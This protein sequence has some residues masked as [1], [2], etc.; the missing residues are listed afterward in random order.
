MSAHAQQQH[1]Q[2]HPSGI[3]RFLGS[4]WETYAKLASFLK[5]YRFRLALG[6][7][8]GIGYAA[9]N[10]GII[11]LVRTITDT[12]FHGKFSQ[13]DL[14][15]GAGMGQ[16]GGVTEF[17]WMIL[18]IPLVMIL[19]G[20]LAYANVYNL[21]WVSLRALRDMRRR[22]FGHL[23]RQSLDFFGRSQSGRLLS[24]VL[25]DT[26]MAQESL[27][28]IVGEL[29]KQPLTA[30]GVIA[31]LLRIDWKFCLFA[32][33]L[34]PLFL[35]PVIIYGRRVR[36]AARA[37]QNEA[38][39]MAVI[40]Q[41]SFAGIRVIKS[42]AREAF[43]LRLFDK[44]S[45]EQFRS[46][47]K[48]KKSTAIVQPM[49]ESV[50]ACGVALALVYVHY[51][52]LSI[53]SFIALLMGMFLLYDP[54]KNLSRIHVV[55]QNCLGAATS[56]LELLDTKPSIHDLPGAM[57]LETT[58]GHLA[59]EGVNFSYGTT[60]TH[61]EEGGNAVTGIS[62]VIE[63][64]M[65]VALVGSSGAGK[66]TLLALLLRFYDPQQGRILIDG[67][68][69]RDLTLLS[70]RE[71]IGIVTQESFLF[72]DSIYENIR[73]GRLDAT[74]AEIEEAARLA[75]AHDFIMAQPHGYETIVGDKGCLLSGGQQQR[76]AIARALLKA[77]PVLLLDEATSALDSE[78]EKMIQDA[79]EKLSRGRTVIAI[80]H[81]LSTVLGSDMIV[82]MD[83]G[84]IVAT[85][86]H[87]ELLNSSEV[88]T[89]LYR[90][91]FSH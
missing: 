59:F 33:V 54:I 9:C 55:L 49:M 30:I 10:S 16:G 60:G 20:L 1:G 65:K 71:Q 14:L 53:G 80:A 83:H 12:A 73:F 44:S 34:F 40:L 24:R 82:V 2:K 85:G 28:S 81:R 74:K 26:Q 64:G 43:Q 67:R 15:K 91:Q 56:T 22:V 52:H 47:M 84:R 75:H 32:F 8:A 19:R 37:V 86:T 18:P 78:S 79:L 29:V 13:S 77:A 72:H 4:D 61:G 63:P 58:R 87:A 41:E 36:K 50:S 70:L 62:L 27:V 21:T 11:L 42:F 31:V 51:S 48:V 25:N 6:L 17:L 69:L 76:L 39:V 7:L 66:S 46:G 45:D 3:F 5:P 90:L 88:Y 23:M 57:P 35:L 38:G 89:N 68:D